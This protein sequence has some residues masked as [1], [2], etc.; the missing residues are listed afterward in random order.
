VAIGSTLQDRRALVVGASSGIGRAV[1]V[2]F[3]ALGA[4]VAFCGRRKDRLETAVAAFGEGSC[5][6]A[7][8][9]TEPADCDRLVATAAERLGG[10]DAI[11]FAAG[12]SRLARLKDASADDWQTILRTN[13]VGPALVVKAALPH[14]SERAVVALLSSESVGQPYP[15]LVPYAASKAALEET[16]RGWRVEHPEFRFSRVTV[17]ATEGTDFGREFDA[18][19]ASDLFPTWI[20]MGKIPARMM[21]AHELG[22]SIADILAVVIRAKGIDCHELTLR[23]PGPPFQGDRSFLLSQVDAAGAGTAS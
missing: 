18:A 4:R 11:V 9:V 2:R 14:L 5:A 23:P 13:V 3:A 12:A 15:G 17:G 22:R 21:D 16:I 19:M 7:A 10:I 8:D 20:S 1:A 6:I